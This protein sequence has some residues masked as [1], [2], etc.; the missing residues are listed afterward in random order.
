M[1]PYFH[2]SEWIA[3]SREIRTEPEDNLSKGFDAP[4]AAI[5][6]P[7][8]ADGPSE[9]AARSIDIVERIAE[10]VVVVALVGELIAMFGNVIT[11]SFFGAPLLW[12]LEIGE[13]SIVIM[14]FV[15]GAIAYPRNEHMA[16]TLAVQALPSRWRPT[17]EALAHWQVFVVGIAGAW[18]AYEMMLSR[19]DERTPYLEMSAFWFALPMVCGMLLLA[20]FAVKRAFVHSVGTAVL[21]GVVL[22]A[23]F[24]LLFGAIALLGSD[25][26][27]YALAIVFAVFVVQLLLGVPIG[28]VLLVAS[29]VYLTTSATVPLSVVPI[30]MQHG[31]SSFIML[32][33]PFFVLAGYVMTEGGL[34]RRLTDF[35][36]MLVGRVRGGM[37]QVVVV[38]MYI[39]SGISGSKVADVAAVGTTMKRV[40]RR[41]NYDSGEIAAVLASCAIMGETVPPSIA[42]LVPPR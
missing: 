24:V 27:Q 7:L 18:L 11:R 29:L 2:D 37:L 17:V 3:L 13:L 28:F 41:E 31:I 30:N 25:A 6:R 4:V 39:M 8:A 22:V 15:G 1:P 14:A 32:S 20:Y 42:M 10:A 16:L 23:A 26:R 5:D 34:S 21:S 35:V 36:M 9:R 38:S 33:I 12:S 19:W 40:L